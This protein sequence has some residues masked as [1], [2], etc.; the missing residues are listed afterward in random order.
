MREKV[1]GLVRDL[2]VPVSAVCS[3]SGVPDGLVAAK[4]IRAPGLGIPGVRKI[5]IW[6]RR[7]DKTLV[8]VRRGRSA[9]VLLL[10]GSGPIDRNSNHKRI[11]FEV[12][13]QVA[14]ALAAVGVASFRYDE[15][16]VGS[17]PG[18]WRTVGLWD[19]VDDAAAAVDMLR[20]RP[21]IDPSGVAVAGHSEGAVQ[22]VALAARD[23]SIAG[24]ILLAGS[25]RNG[26]EVLLW[27]TRTILPTL[28]AQ[29]RFLLRVLPFDPAARVSRNHARLKGTTEDVVRMDGQRINAKWFREFLAYN[30][31]D[32][33]PKIEM[34]VLAIT[35]AK[36]LQVN[37]DDLT[38]IESSVGGPVATRLVPDVTHSLRRQAGPPS[39]SKYKREVREPVDAEVLRLVTDWAGRHLV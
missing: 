21:E 23:R 7:G 32:D 39:L 37:P 15:H 20:A 14:E 35:G 4:G 28:P 1:G 13:A 10:T 31:A 2:D 25:A 11:R 5:G 6:R 26:E 17:S 19:N 36:D 22:A 27:Q 38:I 8:S 34:P 12:T 30:P 18:D 3:V 33:L 29:V 24:A 16:G 9:V